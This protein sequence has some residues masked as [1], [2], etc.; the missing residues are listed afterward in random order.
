MTDSAAIAWTR[1]FTRYVP[2]RRPL[3][4]LD[5][6]SGT[7]RFAA[8][9]AAEFGGPVYGVEPRERHRL[10]APSC[11]GV[12]YLDG[13]AEAIPLP[14]RRVDVVLLFQVLHH[15]DRLEATFAEVSRVA[16]A[17]GTVLVRGSFVG[18]VCRPFWYQFFP[19]AQAATPSCGRAEDVAA[20]AGRYGLDLVALDSHAVEPAHRLDEWYAR[21]KVMMSSGPGPLAETEVAAGLDA[22]ARA[23]ADHPGLLIHPP[24]ADLMVLRRRL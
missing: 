15:V 12:T 11:D 19:G 18:R 8:A 9:L 5:L 14:D 10:A 23:V 13:R 1:V 24:P 3:S 2:S 22:M 17:E 6:G 7:G 20:L 4:V 16:A 21:L